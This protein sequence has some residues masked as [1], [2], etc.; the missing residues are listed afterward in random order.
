MSYQE[1]QEDG[2][3]IKLKGKYE[4]AYY[5]PCHSCG[6]PTYSRNYIRTHR[7][8]CKDCKTNVSIRKLVKKTS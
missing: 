8:T 1:A 4:T 6:Q 2:I 3:M 7:Y 5:P